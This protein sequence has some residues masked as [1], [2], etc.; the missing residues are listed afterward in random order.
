MSIKDAAKH[1]RKW[2][3]KWHTWAGITAGF[4]LIIVS[5]TGALLVFE[6]EL[7]VWLNP[8]L[9]EYQETG[10]ILSFEEVVNQVS[11]DHPEW[12]VTRIFIQEK[13]NDAYLVIVKDLRKQVIVNPYTAKVAGTR[14]YRKTVMGFIRNLHRTLLIPFVGRYIVGLCSLACVILMITGLRQWLPSKTKQ[15]KTRLKIRLDA[16][17]RRVNYDTHN[18]LGFYFAPII[19]LI[20]LTGVMITFS[21]IILLFLF[22]LNFQSPQS[23]ASILDQRSTYVAN[24]APIGITKAEELVKER[25]LDA[26]VLGVSLPHDSTGTYEMNVW[27]PA[28]SKVGDRSLVF[29]DQYSGATVFSTDK[30][31]LQLGKV[32]LNWV[33]PVHYGTFGGLFTRILAL[34]ASLITAVLFLTGFYIWYGRWKKRQNRRKAKLKQT[35]E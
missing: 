3:G 12:K 13:K 31:E 5:L 22:L 2:Y 11:E 9:F 6:Q 4:V 8:Q 14:V 15:L 19:S 17:K 1:Q 34:V 16:G 18:A 7:D 32:Y 23:I 10:A 35:K 33:T 30:K 24:Q 27:Q 26:K 20:A 25:M 29:I 28:P 21:Q